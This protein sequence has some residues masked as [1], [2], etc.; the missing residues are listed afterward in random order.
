MT[1]NLH[2]SRLLFGL[3]IILLWPLANA[4]GCNPRS[5]GELEGE[6]TNAILGQPPTCKSKWFQYN[7]PAFSSWSNG[8]S[9]NLPVVTAAAG[10]YRTPTL[11]MKRGIQIPATNYQI[12]YVQWW[13]WF[14]ASQLQ[15]APQTFEVP[16]PEGQP[17]VAPPD[18]RNLHYFGGN[19]LFSNIYQAG[20]ITSVV[21]VRSWAY[22]H[23]S[24]SATPI[25]GAA[26]LI[27]L[28]E[29][30]LKATWAVFG[31][32][33]SDKPVSLYN[34][35]GR[36][37][38]TWPNPGVGN[39]IYRSDAPIWHGP[40]DNLAG[41]G[42]LIYGGH[43][44]AL[45]GARSRLIN[46][47]NYDDR[48]PLF[49]RAIQYTQYSRQYESVNQTAVLTNLPWTVPS[50]GTQAQ[51]NLYGLTPA[52][53]STL[54]ALMTSGNTSN[55]STVLGWL[56]GVTKDPQN[57]QL[58]FSIRT[59]T[60]YRILG[61]SGVRAS[62]VE[63]NLD[64]NTPNI[65][66][67]CYRAVDLSQPTKSSATFLFPWFDGHKTGTN[68]KCTLLQGGL[69]QATNGLP[70]SPSPTPPPV[71]STQLPVSQPLFHVVLSKG[72]DAYLEP[73][74]PS[75]WPPPDPPDPKVGTYD[76]PVTSLPD[77]AF[78]GDVAW[79]FDSVPAGGISDGSNEG[80]NWIDTL[81]NPD[82]ESPLEHQSNLVPGL[83]HQHFFSGATDTLPI[84]QGE[85]LYAW[86]YLDPA[87]P[88]SEVMLQ[89]FE[90]R[91]AWE[92]RAFWGSD[93]IAYGTSGQSSRYYMGSLPAVGQWVRLEVPA[94]SVGLPGLSVNGM[95][96]ALYGGQATWGEAGKNIYGIQSYN[97]AVGQPATQSSTYLAFPPTIGPAGLAVDG[98]SD[99]NFA[100]SSF[101]QT[102]DDYQ[103]W[104]QVDL[105]SSY[106][107]NSINVWNRTDCCS[108][109]LSAF[110]VLVC[111]QPFTSTSLL[112]TI[113]QP[114]VSSYYVAGTAGTP[115][116]F[117]T[118]RSGRYVRVQLSGTNYLTL[119]EVE[120]IGQP[121]PAIQP[122]STPPTDTV[123][124]EDSIPA[125]AVPNGTNEIWLW[126]TTNPAP[127]SGALAHQSTL[128]PNLMHQHY[129]SSATTPL[130]VN[131]GEKLVTYVYLDPIN[132]PTEVMLQWLEPGAAWEHRAF[133]GADQIAW[134]TSGQSSRHYMG[135]LPPAGQWVRL[136]VPV[137]NV[138]LQGLSINGMAFVLFG[139]QAT[140]DHSGKG[141]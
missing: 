27:T 80:W 58:P 49:D 72:A 48:W 79:V 33:A 115:T 70:A 19:E 124:V 101:T 78:G 110:Y 9:L 89:W 139:G 96:F 54:Q 85:S 116:T 64:G 118:P 53:I 95:A 120:V 128:V 47:W 7:D 23:T 87:N 125:G 50:S 45:A 66:G 108:D 141:L 6:L 123:W 24:T 93:Q 31:L 60:T 22:N 138:G 39:T 14:L 30:Y 69:M 86:V 133:W 25:A 92:H 131:A 35:P 81:P 42:S 111:D 21:A 99:G 84:N 94:S 38:V 68:G 77:T 129:F 106:A 100:A 41:D 137:A 91:A 52:D 62:T 140:W 29:L 44:L 40:H 10:L 32:S 43:F 88:P 105:G 122:G 18:Q 127:V 34:V 102:N 36:S 56:A 126:G 117:T 2:T 104:W 119:A 63:Q 76:L 74:P 90:P 134:G 73:K 12:T 114:G 57:N 3:L 113:N 61:W 5:P 37:A 136:E 71:V 28:S 15:V 135:P 103:A 59:V 4:L 20:V 46:H 1:N 13:I 107:L 109:R 65:F 97:L 16:G 67:Q 75:N 11:Y 98:I 82:S 121:L 83:A 51:E 17:F 8:A 55:V 26:S 132:P 112:S 130:V